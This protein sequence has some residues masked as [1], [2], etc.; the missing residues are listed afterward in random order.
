M[1]FDVD[2]IRTAVQEETLL[3]NDE[4]SEADVTEEFFYDTWVDD[5]DEKIVI[6]LNKLYAELLYENM[7]Y[8]DKLECDMVYPEI[9]ETYLRE[10]LGEYLVSLIL[11]N[12]IDLIEEEGSCKIFSDD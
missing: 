9:T 4:I 8:H 5:D 2:K 1:E 6:D 7:T 11:N 12:F 10:G 3:F